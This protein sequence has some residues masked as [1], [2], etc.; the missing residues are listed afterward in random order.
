MFALGGIDRGGQKFVDLKTAG[1]HRHGESGGVVTG[2]RQ[3]LSE[4]QELRD[5]VDAAARMRRALLA[6]PLV[7][8]RFAAL[9]G[10]ATAVMERPV[11]IQRPDGRPIT[12]AGFSCASAGPRA[13][14]SAVA[15]SWLRKEAVRDGDLGVAAG[16]VFHLDFVVVAELQP[17]DAGPQLAMLDEV[18]LAAAYETLRVAADGEADGARRDGLAEEIL[19]EGD[20]ARLRWT[21]DALGYDLDRPHRAAVFKPEDDRHVD[22]AFVTAIQVAAYRLG[23]GEVVLA[24][25]DSVVLLATADVDW[26][27]FHSDVEEQSGR[28]CWVGLGDWKR[29]VANLSVSR[30]EARLAI[31]LRRFSTG[32]VSQFKDLGS[33]GLLASFETSPAL[34]DFVEGSIGP[35]VQ[36]DQ[37]KNVELLTTL[38]TYLA[39]GCNLTTSAAQLGI[40]RNTLKYRLA[41]VKALSGLDPDDPADRFNLQLAAGMRAVRAAL[42][43]EPA[44]LGD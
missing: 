27:E 20:P 10:E 36:Y 29:D 16:G 18:A 34:R 5:S 9:V 6:V 23:A 43:G 26:D 37:R 14:K 22:G 41:R 44:A 13:A 4:L 42:G 39:N 15:D 1:G 31:Q 2:E 28:T 40:H 7:P 33:Y 17:D 8:S 35:I 21:A 32:S 12:S 25:D 11:C 30:A 24:I 19:G 3:L 38:E